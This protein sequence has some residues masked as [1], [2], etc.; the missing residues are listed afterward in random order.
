[1]GF[2]SKLRT[3]GKTNMMG[4][5]PYLQ[6]EFNLS[7]KESRDLLAYWI[8]SYRNPDLDESL[9]EVKVYIKDSKTRDIKMLKFKSSKEY[10]ANSNKGL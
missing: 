6:A 10:H 7:K 1:M 3:S 4:A 8:D 9:N 2:L 5:A